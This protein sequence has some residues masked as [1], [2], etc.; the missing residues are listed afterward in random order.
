MLEGS[1]LKYSKIKF[2]ESLKE[3]EALA[4]L[5]GADLTGFHQDLLETLH[6]ESEVLDILK[7]ME[8]VLADDSY[9]LLLE[10]TETILQETYIPNTMSKHDIWLEVT[11][12][13]HRMIGSGCPHIIIQDPYGLLLQNSDVVH[14]TALL[15]TCP[16]IQSTN[17]SMVID[18]RTIKDPLVEKQAIKVLKKLKS[19][20]PQLKVFHNQDIHDREIIINKKVLHI[21][22]SMNG[23]GSRDFRVSFMD[24]KESSD[25]R[26][27]MKAT[28]GPITRPKLVPLVK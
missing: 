26:H 13:V 18:E 11:R 1:K 20:F 25:A 8:E 3:S 2:L 4:A 21:G 17:I 12:K 9:D 10:S 16:N 28:I 22:A 7:H 23:Y 24:S 6:E 27:R 19:A 14:L 5:D 15:M